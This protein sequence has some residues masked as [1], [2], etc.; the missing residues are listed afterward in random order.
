MARRRRPQTD[1]MNLLDW[2]PADP[3][4][5]FPAERLKA[6][7]LARSISK[8]V[9]ETLSRCGRSREDVA[10]AMTEYLDGETISK[11]VLDGYAAE[12]RADLIINLVRLD[13]LL[14]VTRDSTILEMI[15]RRHGWMVVERRYLDAIKLAD[16]LEHGE[17]VKR[18]AE[19]YRRR[20]RSGGAS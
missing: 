8:G 18:E 13:A 10:R 19:F 17:E 12:S 6:S 2:R 5:T 20:F 15:A 3:T 16:L 4:A 7:T 9:S 11:G 14:A 1:Q